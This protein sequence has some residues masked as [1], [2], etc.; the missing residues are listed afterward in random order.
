[1][2]ISFLFLTFCSSFGI[3]VIQDFNKLNSE[4]QKKNIISWNPVVADIVRGFS[5]LDDKTVRCVSLYHINNKL[6]VLSS[7]VDIFPQSI[8]R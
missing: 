2:D 4:T 1:M 3:L 7:S 6:I 8:L 5:T